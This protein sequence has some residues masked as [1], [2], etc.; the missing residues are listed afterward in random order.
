MTAMHAAAKM[1]NPD[2]LEFMVDNS[3]QKTAF[4]D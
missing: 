1:K 3:F 2:I 4:S